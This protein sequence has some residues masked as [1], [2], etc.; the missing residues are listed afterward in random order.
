[1]RNKLEYVPVSSI[2]FGD[3]RRQEYTDM[4]QLK[5]S[6]KNEGLHEPLVIME[7]VDETKLHYL[8]L[9]GGRRLK[10]VI[11]LGPAF[12]D[13]PQVACHIYPFMSDLR[14]RRVIELSENINRANL[15]WQEEARLTA[16]IHNLQVEIHGEPVSAHDPQGGQTITATA[17]LLNRDRT[18]VT[19]DLQIAEALVLNPELAKI[20]DK[21][22][23][24]TQILKDREIK[25]IKELA[26]RMRRKASTADITRSNLIDSFVVGMTLPTMRS[27]E[28]ESFH[29]AEID[30]PYGIELRHVVVTTSEQTEFL[31]AATMNQDEKNAFIADKVLMFKEVYRL[32][33]PNAWMILW[34]AVDPW[35]EPFYQ[36]ALSAGFI[37]TRTPGLWIK[38][39]GKTRTPNIHLANWFEPFMYFRKGNAMLARPGARNVFSFGM[40]PNKSHPTEK[41]IEL[42]E[43]VLRTFVQPN[44]RV[45]SPYCGSG[46]IMLA[47]ANAE[48]SAIGIDR[49]PQ[50][51][52]SFTLKVFAAQPKQYRSY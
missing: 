29:F 31:E 30:P 18:S 43:E 36:A 28:P 11:E 8:L 47:A 10:A 5:S 25:T 14:M 38:N 6:I 17:Q 45:L 32:L 52:E 51:K 4:D 15:T 34:Y 22:A 46:N 44:A 2:D 21:T 33:K 9:A 7:Q 39:N 24:Y 35:G 40:I 26:S 41:P 1:M 23:A 12:K 3:R 16:E 42:Y 27:M 37:G 50:Y 19:K 20:K 13:Y 48:M 49:D